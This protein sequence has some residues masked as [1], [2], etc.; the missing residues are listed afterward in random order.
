[1]K[2]KNKIHIRFCGL[3]T[4][5]DIVIENESVLILY[6]FLEDNNVILAMCITNGLLSVCFVNWHCDLENVILLGAV[7]GKLR[8]GN[9]VMCS[10]FIAFLGYR[11]V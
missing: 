1:M 9:Y 7:R 5:I 8:L 3:I 4:C 10:S 11:I 6:F 2:S